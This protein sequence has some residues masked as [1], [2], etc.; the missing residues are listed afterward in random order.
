MNLLIPL[1][2]IIIGV[3]S[4]I[5]GPLAT[6]LNAMINEKIRNQPLV[7]ILTETKPPSK[8][9]RIFA[10]IVVR[11]ITVLFY[12]VFYVVIMIDNYR[13]KKRIKIDL[14]KGHDVHPLFYSGLGGRGLLVCKNCGLK[15]DMLGFLHGHDNIVWQ[16]SG[17]QCQACGKLHKIENDSDYKLLNACECG[18]MLSRD[19]PIFCPRCK[20]DKVKYRMDFI[21]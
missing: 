17:Y 6:R 9:K 1:I 4:N 5:V 3:I 8:Q 20:S 19:K 15:C 2:Y 21:T 13:E 12:P 10:E 11:T 16:I 18:G 14:T 7:D